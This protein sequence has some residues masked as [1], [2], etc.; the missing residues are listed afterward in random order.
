MIPLTS[1]AASALARLRTRAE[2]FGPVE[3]SH[4]VFA[5]FVLKFNFR[6]KKVIGYGVTGFDPTT[7]IKQLAHGMALSDEEGGA[8]R[9]P[10]S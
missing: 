4:F 1:V 5:A 9:I 8:S 2:S 3:P 6:E 7:H 10:F